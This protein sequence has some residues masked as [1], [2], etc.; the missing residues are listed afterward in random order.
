MLNDA[1]SIFSY[2]ADDLLLAN[3][4]NWLFCAK[5][6]INSSDE[7]VCAIVKKKQQ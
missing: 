6:A 7:S 2:V 4:R 1:N 3:K 5:S